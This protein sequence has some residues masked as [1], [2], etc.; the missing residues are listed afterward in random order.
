MRPQLSPSNP[1]TM[2]SKEREWLEQ[3]ASYSLETEGGMEGWEPRWGEGGDEGW[4]EWCKDT[5]L[6]MS[7]RGRL[8]GKR[9]CASLTPLDISAQ[10]C[11]ARAH[12]HKL[13]RQEKKKRVL[14]VTG[15]QHLNYTLLVCKRSQCDW[16]STWSVWQHTS[17]LLQ[18][19]ASNCRALSFG[20]FF[21]SGA[22]QPNQRQCERLWQRLA[23]WVCLFIGK[24]A[25]AA[26]Y[27]ENAVANV[28][29][30]LHFHN[31]IRFTAGRQLW[32]AVVLGWL[33][34]PEQILIR[35][36]F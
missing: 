2:S 12:S 11:S 10:L 13:G 31:A 5:S 29:V 28:F 1:G 22:H 32:D 33:R 35:T 4:W 19:V 9:G 25:H 34:K 27:K 23:V 15:P 6:T 16:S 21:L 30:K 8:P 24:N 18:P 26:F 20:C 36:D 14:V 3:R 7:Q 17:K